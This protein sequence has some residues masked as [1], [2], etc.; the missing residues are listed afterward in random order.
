MIGAWRGRAQLKECGEFEF[1][2]VSMIDLF[3]F[4]KHLFQ[5]EPELIA[6]FFM[7]VIVALVFLLS[8]L[9]WLFN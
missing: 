5:N 6:V 4:L 8:P 2:T 9:Y 7:G 1:E 3:N